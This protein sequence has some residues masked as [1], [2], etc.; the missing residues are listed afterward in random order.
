MDIRRIVPLL[1]VAAAAGLLAAGAG[2]SS[3]ATPFP[4]TIALPPGFQPEG[5]AIHRGRFFVGSIPTGAIYSGSLLTGTGSILVQGVPG[6]TGRSATGIEA[7]GRGRL[8]VAGANRGHAYVYN[9][10]TGALLRDYTLT[11]DASFINDVVVTPRAAFFTDSFNQRLYKLAFGPAGRL[12]AASTPLPLTGD[13]AFTPGFNANGIDATPSGG[14]LVIVQS[15]T[16]FLFRVDPATGATDRI[17]L[18]GAATL[19]NGDGI[20]LDG[21]TLYVVRN[22]NNLIAVVR[23]APG[24]GSGRVATSISPVASGPFAVPT[25]IDEHGNFLYAVNARFGIAAP[26]TQAFNLVKVRKR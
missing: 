2:A 20:L 22:Q 3:S 23:L 24:L 5:I 15:N 4:A 26:E 19:T 10:R 18:A 11:T 16:G 17:E 14:R 6:P 25:T 9:A 8:F 7:D 1:A 21:K 13:I 12:P